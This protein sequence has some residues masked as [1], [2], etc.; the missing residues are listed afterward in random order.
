MLHLKTFQP[1]TYITKVKTISK[2]EKYIIKYKNKYLC[3]DLDFLIEV[4]PRLQNIDEL[5]MNRTV[6]LSEETIFRLIT[7]KKE[8]NLSANYTFN[9]LDLI[10]Q[11]GNVIVIPTTTQDFI[12]KD[13][14]QQLNLQ[15]QEPLHHCLAYYSKFQSK[16][17]DQ[18]LVLFTNS[19]ESK[20]IAKGIGLNTIVYFQ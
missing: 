6:V 15:Y 12:F 14:L 19:I 4:F 16:L 10:T 18:E 7:L 1:R 17:K 8:K 11:I 5:F 20:R 9:I 2:L 13:Y 3:F